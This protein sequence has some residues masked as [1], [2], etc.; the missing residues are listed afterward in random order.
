VNIKRPLSVCLGLLLLAASVQAGQIT[1]TFDFS[2]LQRGSFSLD[3]GS[4]GILIESVSAGK[5]TA[6][7]INDS[8]LLPD[9]HVGQIFDTYC[10]DLLHDINNNESAQ[11]GLG[12]MQNWTQ[13]NP[14]G[15]GTNPGYYPWATN[16]YAGSAAAYLYINYRNDGLNQ[17]DKTAREAGLQLAIWEVLYEGNT[18][19]SGLPSYNIGNGKIS[20]SGFS[21]DV[22]GFANTY[23]NG[24]SVDWNNAVT[25][26]ALWLKTSNVGDGLH[27][28]TQDFIATNAVPEPAAGILVGSGVALLA[29]MQYRKKR[30]K[31]MH[32]QDGRRD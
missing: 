6:H 22:T 20:F 26:N 2:R 8:G 4:A 23:L 29:G 21:S 5:G 15:Q 17:P 28:H 30:A 16:P 7:V 32:A 9:L 27:S 3:R 24:L 18:L 12:S 13:P 10:I 31:R 19:D 25:A 14:G 11:V 1:F